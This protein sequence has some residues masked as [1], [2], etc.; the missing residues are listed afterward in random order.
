MAIT[1]QQVKELRDKTGAGMMDCKTALQEA[2]GDLEKAVELLRK[3][4]IAK[5]EKKSAR[6]AKDGL[7]HAYIHPGGKL[8]VLIEVN[9]ETDFVAKTED[10]YNLVHNLAMHIAAS[11]PIAIDREKVPEEVVKRE[12]RLFEEEARE[13]GK[14]DHVVEKIAAGKLEKFYAENVLMEQAYIRD[15]EKTVKDYLT[16][17]IAKVGENIN[18]GRFVRYQ[19]GE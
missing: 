8:G 13:S 5:A 6:E 10:F 12:K 4:G 17:V 1:A 14:P 15:T 19:I 7:V 11:N 9:C 3:K 18:I 2:E 16:E